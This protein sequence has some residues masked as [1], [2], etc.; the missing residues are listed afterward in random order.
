MS[1]NKIVILQEDIDKVLDYLKREGSIKKK[2]W[3][4]T[5]FATPY[6]QPTLIK[7]L[8][9]STATKIWQKSP[10][11]KKQALAHVFEIKI[12]NEKNLDERGVFVMAQNEGAFIFSYKIWLR[13]TDDGKTIPIKT[14]FTNRAE[15]A[16]DLFLN[17]VR[18]NKLEFPLPE[19]L[20]H[21][22]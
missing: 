11:G 18:E 17:E 20:K 1:E 15:K 10:F 2:Y 21:C 13:V 8:N 5:F 16:V 22:F 14:Y 6:K 3:G 12:L 19:T 4:Y 7:A 9:S